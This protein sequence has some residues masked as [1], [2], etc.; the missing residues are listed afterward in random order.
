MIDATTSVL[1]PLSSVRKYC[2]R[3]RDRP[4]HPAT[5]HRWRL[6]GVRGVKLDA[7]KL[8][9]RWYTTEQ[10]VQRFVAVLSGS[11]VSPV[12]ARPATSTIKADQILETLG[13]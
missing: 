13:I 5:L 2:L 12:E 1:I 11:G 10:A 6:H 7:V 9:G 4:I 8:G 3:T